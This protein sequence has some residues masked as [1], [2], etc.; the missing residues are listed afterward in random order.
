L[1]KLKNNQRNRAKQFHETYTEEEKEL[2]KAAL[3]LDEVTSSEMPPLK[4]E[5]GQKPTC[6]S[7]EMPPHRYVCMYVCM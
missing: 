2:W 3:G 6:F 7:D 5:E 4:V 1:S